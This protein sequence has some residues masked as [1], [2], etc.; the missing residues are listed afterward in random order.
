M[1]AKRVSCELVT[2]RQTGQVPAANRKHPA[3]V[4]S[5]E[6]RQCFGGLG[7]MTLAFVQA[8]Q[9]MT[10]TSFLQTG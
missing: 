2:A 8:A 4:F 3:D 6:S 7:M 1:K 10:H 5:C 9:A